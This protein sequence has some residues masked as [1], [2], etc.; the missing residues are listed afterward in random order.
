MRWSSGCAALGFAAAPFED[1]NAEP[2]GPCRGSPPAARPRGR[3]VFASGNVMLLS[4]A[5]W[6]GLAE[7][8]VPRPA[9]CCC[10]YR[11]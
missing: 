6:S 8:M 9:A 11:L 7:D 10:G 3:R 1:A 2:R 4:V 5:V